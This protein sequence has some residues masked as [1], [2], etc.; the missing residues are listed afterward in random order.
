MEA[1]VRMQ[2]DDREDANILLNTPETV[3]YTRV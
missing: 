2:M 1:K 3:A